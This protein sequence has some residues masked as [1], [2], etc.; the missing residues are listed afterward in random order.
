[1]TSGTTLWARNHF[2]FA[3]V[4]QAESAVFVNP[5]LHSS[6]VNYLENQYNKWAADP[7]SVSNSLATFFYNLQTGHEA[8]QAHTL[9][10]QNV[11]LFLLRVCPELMRH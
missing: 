2:S 10:D 8:T 7:S 6:N 5:F 9:V 4:K 1:M 11:R 3:T